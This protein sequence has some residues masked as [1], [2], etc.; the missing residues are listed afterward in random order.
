MEQT[1]RW[2]GPDDPVTINDIRQTGATG[3]VTALHHIP[4][5]EVWSL[6]EIQRRCR[7][8][9]F[10]NDQPT[11]LSWSVVESVPVTEAIKLRNGDY[12]RHIENYQKTLENLSQ[13]GI[14]TVCYN[15][16]PVLDWTRTDLAYEMPDGSRALRFDAVDFAAFDLFIL[17]RPTAKQDYN[18]QLYDKAQ[19]RF[20]SLSSES[21]KRLTANIIA[22]LPGSEEDYTVHQLQS[23][24]DPYQTISSKQLKENLAF[25]LK[26]VIP[27]AQRH[28]ICMAIHP[29][30]PPWPLLGLPRIASTET[31][32]SDILE[33]VDSPA[34]SIT[35][36]CG[37]LG[38]VKGIDLAGLV[39]RL[40]HRIGFVHLR[41]ISRET[42]SQSFHEADHLQGDHNMFPIVRNLL[43]EQRRRKQEGRSDH[44]IPMRPDHGHQMLDDMNKKTNPGYSCIGRMRG[45]AE[46]R[47]LMTGIEHSLSLSN[48]R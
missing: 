21:I 16:M 26:Q 9:E 6:K 15:F 47:G 46:L 33:M 22:G 17:K 35:L 34:N 37:S 32:L 36:C 41:N 18:A 24:I 12:L 44:C 3:I 1:W 30:D 43:L 38:P 14:K 10:N 29:D 11:G 27:V 23:A 28:D 48:E 39:E 13:C 4:N 7:E 2:F 20:K 45:L 25:F 42:D 8:I 31:D 40:G 19:Q 5:G